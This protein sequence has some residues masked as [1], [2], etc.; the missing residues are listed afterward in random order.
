[1]E[2]AAKN[3]QENERRVK[4]LGKEGKYVLPGVDD[5]ERRKK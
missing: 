1:L 5:L 3:R 4:P 2:S